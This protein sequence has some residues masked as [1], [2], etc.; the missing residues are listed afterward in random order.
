M[1][2]FIKTRVHTRTHTHKYLYKNNVKKPAKKLTILFAF[3]NMKSIKW[4]VFAV[5]MYKNL[6][7]ERTEKFKF[8]YKYP[9]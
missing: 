5:S 4:V 8:L 1:G 6:F 9:E 3:K 7:H 2:K